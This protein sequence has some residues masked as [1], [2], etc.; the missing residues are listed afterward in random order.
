[1]ITSGCSVCINYLNISQHR[2]FLGDNILNYS[3][4][5]FPGYPANKVLFPQSF[6]LCL[7][8]ITIYYCLH[9]IITLADSSVKRKCGMPMFSIIHEMIW[10]FVEVFRREKS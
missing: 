2:E 7:F 5:K 3:L 1:M 8:L 6:Q 10:F 9:N 4:I